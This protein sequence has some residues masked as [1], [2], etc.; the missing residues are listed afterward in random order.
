MLIIIVFQLILPCYLCS[1]RVDFV[2]STT[3][4]F[5]SPEYLAP[6]STGWGELHFKGV[7]DGGDEL[8]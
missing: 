3:P 4:L 2:E 7:L 1:Y 5:D 8:F 6:L